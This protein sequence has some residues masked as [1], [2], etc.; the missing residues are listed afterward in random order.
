M[1]RV[2][3]IFEG[4]CG[5]SHLAKLLDSHVHGICVEEVLHSLK[6][7]GWL[8]QKEWLENFFSRD[9]ETD[10]N[11]KFL[12]MKSK[13]RAIDQKNLNRFTKFII[14]NDFKLIHLHRKDLF[15]QT[16]SSLRAEEMAYI[17]GTYNIKVG[18]D[19]DLGPIEIR[20]PALIRRARYII[21]EELRID[22]YLMQLPLGVPRLE[23]AYED[24]VSHKNEVL[25]TVFDYIGVPFMEIPDTY[26]K[27][28]NQD[29]SSEIKNWRN[30]ESWINATK[31]LQRS[32]E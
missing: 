28:T 21:E 12:G 22:E 19:F 26:R 15:R 16:I 17:N 27:M 4:R 8:N 6:P 23:I 5:S 24:L 3:I 14:D 2:W 25:N 31:F 30:V 7:Q 32:F 29:V 20:L 9:R 11:I 13:L 1:E 10:V 18:E